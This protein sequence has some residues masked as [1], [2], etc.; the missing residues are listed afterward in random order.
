MKFNEDDK[1]FIKNIN[2]VRNNRANVTPNGAV[3]PKREYNLEYKS[4]IPCNV[5]GKWD[6]F[7]PRNSHMIPAAIRKIHLSKI[8]NTVP[9][10]WGKGSVRREFMYA[11]DLADFINYCLINYEFLE[12]YTNVGI[13]NDYSILNY[14]KEIASVVGYKGDFK[15]E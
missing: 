4:I 12:N 13:G 14:Y 7:D 6:K 9:V 10:I 8:N 1:I 3:V 5:Y 2:K 15:F 11:E